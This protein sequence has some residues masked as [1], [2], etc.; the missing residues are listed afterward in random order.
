MS[1]KQQDIFNFKKIPKV[2]DYSGSSISTFS[3]TSTPYSSNTAFTSVNSTPLAGISKEFKF[4]NY[5]NNHHNSSPLSG[6]RKT[7]LNFSNIK[8]LNCCFCNEPLQ[9]I[10]E[11][12][13]IVD[14]K[15]G[16]ILH[17]ECLKEMLIPIDDLT[18]NLNTNNTTNNNQE[19]LICPSC[20]QETECNDSTLMFDTT[21]IAAINTKNS[22][23]SKIYDNILNPHD[24]YSNIMASIDNFQLPNIPLQDFNNS[25]LPSPLDSKSSKNTFED[26]ITPQNQ[27]GKKFWD[28]EDELVIPS[29][30]NSSKSISIKSPISNINSNDIELSK[31]LFAPEF[32]SIN[33]NDKSLKTD[34]GCVI[35]VSVTE[36]E[37]S[38]EFKKKEQVKTQIGK[39]KITDIIINNIKQNIPNVSIDFSSVGSLILFDIIDITIKLNT[40]NS[41][42][43]FLFESNIIILNFDGTQLILNQELNLQTFISSIYL[44][45]K[46]II[47]NMN[48]IKIPSIIFNSNNKILRH[49]WWVT[50]NKIYKKISITNSIPLIQTSTN[51][52]NLISNDN[53]DDVLPNDIKIFNKLSKRG[54]DLPSSFLKRQILR[55]DSIP[56][57]LI[58]AIPLINNEDY[59]LENDEYADIIKGLLKNILNLMHDDDKLGI[60]FLGNNSKFSTLGNY[61]GCTSKSWPGWEIMLESITHNVINEEGLYINFWEDSLSNIELLSNLGFNQHSNNNNNNK[62]NIDYLKQIIFISNELLIDNFTK[63]KYFKNEEIE[64]KFNDLNNP[65][66]KKKKNN[67]NL[68]FNERILNICQKFEAN[69]NLILLADEFKFEVNQIFDMNKYLNNSNKLNDYNNEIKLSI[70][71][72]FENLGNILENLIEKLHNVTIKE[73]ETCINFPKNVQL[74]G[75]ETKNG[76]EKFVNDNYNEYIIKM[77]NL[78]SGFEKSLMFNVHVDFSNENIN[79]IYKA[80]IAT[81]KSKFISDKEITEFENQAD[82]KLI[83]NESNI[84]SNI[85]LNLNIEKTNDL[86]K[87]PININENSNLESNSIPISIRPQSD[88]LNLSIMSRLSNVSDAYYIKRKIQLLVAEKV[89]ECVLEVKKFDL[90]E[91]EN[92]KIILKELIQTIWEFSNS[93]NSS[94][95]NNIKDNEQWSEKL[96]LE[97]EEI[98]DG[99]SLRNYQLS[100]MKCMSLYLEIE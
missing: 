12:E 74:I 77:R 87:N 17:L 1:T 20:N 33:I 29:I 66:L 90:Q 69:F 27:I 82:I 32:S 88:N 63:E 30:T 61:Y 44:K 52:W 39:N 76:I 35:N 23:I 24:E 43:V 72:D 9:N 99:Y 94:N 21:T 46:N 6:Q 59:G 42:Q 93:C 18:N 10:F 60:I 31:I 54:L 97:L 71:L 81:S 36:F 57:I 51:A 3:Q 40:F 95:T 70:A 48:S 49:K 11:G 58:L 14:L 86:F 80:T 34:I 100:N 16:H 67:K 91:K 84:E 56:M 73:L 13:K 96:I 55:P 47:V 37:S 79:N 64:N 5:N 26:P 38:I 25:S 75:F 98:I 45:D 65:F 15:C 83:T 28:H 92:A 50:L 4:N 68:K 2:L 22:T 41:C 53:N 89:R 62:N 19:K 7:S 85:T 78:P 8:D